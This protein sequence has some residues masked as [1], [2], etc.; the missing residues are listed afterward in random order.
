MKDKDTVKAYERPS[1]KKVATPS[2][3]YGIIRVIEDGMTSSG[4]VVMAGGAWS[5]AS[6]DAPKMRHKAVLA[7]TSGRFSPTLGV[8]DSHPAEVGDQVILR[9]GCAIVE[10]YTIP[11]D[12]RMIRLEDIVAWHRPANAKDTLQ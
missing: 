1:A 2:F 3:G 10:H 8:T 7:A 5:G 9:P 12:C 4:L 11:D 6:D